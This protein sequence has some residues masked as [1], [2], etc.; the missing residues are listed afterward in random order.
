MTDGWHK[1]HIRM[2]FEPEPY[3]IGGRMIANRKFATRGH[4]YFTVPERKRFAYISRPA[5]RRIRDKAL[6]DG[7]GVKNPV[8]AG[9]MSHVSVQVKFVKSD[10][11]L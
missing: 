11:V 1:L 10:V 4:P 9:E 3:R 6:A 5:L 8:I 2:I 7:I